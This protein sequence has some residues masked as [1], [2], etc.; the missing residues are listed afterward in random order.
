MIDVGERG[1]T[2]SSQPLTDVPIL[3]QEASRMITH[4]NMLPLNGILLQSLREPPVVKVILSWSIPLI[5]LGASKSR[6]LASF[7][8]Q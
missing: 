4:S 7:V 3:F 1:V 5:T 8:L 2:G 6:D